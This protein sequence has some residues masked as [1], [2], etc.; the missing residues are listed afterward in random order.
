MKLLPA[1]L[2]LTVICILSAMSTGVSQTTTPPANQD[3]SKTTKKS[4][5]NP[6]KATSTKSDTEGDKVK[7]DDR[8]STRGLK[9]PPKDA[10]KDANK[11]K[12]ASSDTTTP[13]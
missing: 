5:T 1:R 4:S 10:S 12:P 2:L 11:D 3:T 9:P 13:K 6:K 7:T 8:L